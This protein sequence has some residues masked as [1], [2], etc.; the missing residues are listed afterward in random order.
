MSTAER[1]H[2]YRPRN[3]AACFAAA[4]V[5]N[6]AAM[7]TTETMLQLPRIAARDICIR[8]ADG[9]RLAG[10]LFEPKQASGSLTIV[11]PAVGISSGYY[12]K[13]A[14]YLAERGR[15]SLV[16]DYR[17]MGAS[18]H[19]PSKDFRRGCVTGVS[20]TCR[21]S[22]NGPRAFTAARSPGSGIAWAVSLQAL[23]TT[24]ISSIGNSTLLR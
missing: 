2:H 10:T 18:R 16:F 1:F 13:F 17:G 3:P 24:M 5:P 14:S 19:G 7:T 12:R 15:P 9:Y 8:A 4:S 11:A 23:P 20:S 22:S 21:V 6:M